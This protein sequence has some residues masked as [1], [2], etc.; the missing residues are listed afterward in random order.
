[1]RGS[2]FP[3]ELSVANVQKCLKIENKIKNLHYGTI[4]DLASKIFYFLFLFL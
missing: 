3:L 2:L 4:S 1:M